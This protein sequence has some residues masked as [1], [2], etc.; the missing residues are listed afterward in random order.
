LQTEREASAR[1]AACLQ[2][3]GVTHALAEDAEVEVNIVASKRRD[4]E[5]Q[6]QSIA[7]VIA[8]QRAELAEQRRL[9][10]DADTAAAGTLSALSM[11]AHAAEAHAPRSA[12]E[13]LAGARRE[14]RTSLRQVI[15]L[16]KRLRDLSAAHESVHGE[17]AAL[18]VVLSGKDERL[19]SKM[20][21]LADVKKQLEAAL[22]SVSSYQEQLRKMRE[23]HD[24]ANQI[25]RELQSE[26]VTA[27]TDAIKREQVYD[28]KLQA[29]SRKLEARIAALVSKHSSEVEKHGAAAAALQAQ[30]QVAEA[31]RRGAQELAAH[32]GGQH[33]AEKRST[34][35]PQWLWE[36]QDKD[37]H[38]VRS[39]GP[40]LSML[41]TDVC[42][43]RRC[44]LA[45]SLRSTCTHS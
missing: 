25:G 38:E 43:A 16:Q 6:L 34:L 12:A 4:A 32:V 37:V 45:R 8:A 14:L 41:E 11:R 17:K 36:L 44:E 31:A 3:A 28:D 2:S 39:A 9:A 30:L 5:A 40:A 10:A 15:A 18:D 26:L 27:R 35:Q 1:L 20:Q 19:R 33:L 24:V 42:A 23:E 29:A 22:H 21:E 13:Q 7:T